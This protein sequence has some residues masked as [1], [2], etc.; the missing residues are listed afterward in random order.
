MTISDGRAIKN[1]NLYPPARPSL[2]VEIPLW[3][4]LEEYEYIHAL[5]TIG[6]ALNFKT[7]SEDDTIC[8]FIREPTSVT[9]QPYQ[10]LN[11]TVKE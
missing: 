5:W 4:D 10:I 11:S 6:R 8:N 1:M 2:D 7:E 3:M 9:K